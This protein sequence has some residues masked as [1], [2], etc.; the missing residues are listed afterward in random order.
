MIYARRT[1]AIVSSALESL[2]LASGIKETPYN[3]A[4]TFEARDS[5]FRSRQ[6]AEKSITKSFRPPELFPEWEK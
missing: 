5:E 6:K 3:T 2:S 4:P 1:D